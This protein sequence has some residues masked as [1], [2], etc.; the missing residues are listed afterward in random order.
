[1]DV[2]RV[3]DNHDANDREPLPVAVFVYITF[4]PVQKASLS[5]PKISATIYN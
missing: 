1:M 4:Q 3:C 2:V 5:K